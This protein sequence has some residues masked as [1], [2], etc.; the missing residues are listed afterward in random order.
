MID[1][2]K[3]TRF[4]IEQHENA[5][6]SEAITENIRDAAIKRA[7]ASPHKPHVDKSLVKKRKKKGDDSPVKKNRRPPR[8]LIT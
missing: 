5:T 3:Q 7:L 2:R 8:N 6:Q 4:G 1:A